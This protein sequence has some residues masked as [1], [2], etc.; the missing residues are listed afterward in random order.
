MFLGVAL[1]ST[2][3]GFADDKSCWGRAAGFD[4][5]PDY[6]LSAFGRFTAEVGKGRPG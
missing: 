5:S 1:G 6:V 2:P 3:G 4:H